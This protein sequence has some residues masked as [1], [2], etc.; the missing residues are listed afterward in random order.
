MR[1]GVKFH[2]G[3]SFTAEDVEFSFECFEGAATRLDAFVY[4]KGQQLWIKDEE[5]DTWCI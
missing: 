3:D 5:I 1:Q 2:N 4:S